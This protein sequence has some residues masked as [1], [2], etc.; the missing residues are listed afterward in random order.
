MHRDIHTT[1]H[2]VTAHS[3]REP[4]TTEQTSNI[5]SP[6]NT[7][8]NSTAQRV[9]NEDVRSCNDPNEAAPGDDEGN[10]P[11]VNRQGTFSKEQEEE[12]EDTDTVP[13]S[14]QVTSTSQNL[15]CVTCDV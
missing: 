5:L 4:Q 10:K 1:L 7:N 6:S 2:T 11:T 12:E 8:A 13:R 14:R 9:S 15:M 3:R